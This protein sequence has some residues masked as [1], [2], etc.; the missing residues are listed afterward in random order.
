MYFIG[1]LRI[2]SILGVVGVITCRRILFM[3][4]MSIH[5]AFKHLLQH[6]GM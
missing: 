6:L 4:Q 1:C 2:T 3:T 5:F